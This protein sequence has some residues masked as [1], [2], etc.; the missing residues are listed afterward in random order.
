MG[1]PACE[2]SDS[3]ATPDYRC[4]LWPYNCFEL[5]LLD[6]FLRQYRLKELKGTQC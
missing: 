4:G 1:R 2:S 6:C 3:L 5:N